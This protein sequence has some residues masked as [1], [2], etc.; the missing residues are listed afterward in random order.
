MAAKTRKKSSSHLSMYLGVGQEL[1][2]N[3]LPTLR[4]LLRYGIY[5]REVSHV[6][7]LFY[8]I[9]TLVEDMMLALMAQWTK[10]N[11]QL[12]HPIL[13]HPDTIRKR[14]KTSWENAFK[15]STGRGKLKEREKL[16]LQLD[17]LFDILYC[18][19]PIYLCS[20]F[21][22]DPDDCKK[23]CHIKCKCKMWEKIPVLELRFIRAERDKT[24][25]NST[26]MIAGADIPE[27]SKQDKAIKAKD[28]KKEDDEIKAKKDEEIARE[29][30]KREIEANTFINQEDSD[31]VL[32]DPNQN[33]VPPPTKAK[34]K[35]V[36]N[37]KDISN[38][39]LASM[40]HHTGL[41]ETAEIATAAW[42]DAGIITADD[43]HLVIDHNKVRRAQEKL[44]D[45]L[46]KEFEDKL[47][48]KG[49]GC[50]LFDGRI[51]ATKTMMEIEG[52]DKQ[53]PGMIKE[54]HYA[55][56]SEPGGE[57]LWHFVPEKAT[58]QK[59]HAEIIAD[60]I[61]DWLKERSID[62]YLV[63]I[64]GDST[65]VNTGWEGGAMQWVEK[66]LGRRLVWLVCDLHTGELGLRHLIIGIDGPTLSHNRWSGPLGGMLDTATELEVNPKFTKI[67]VGPPPLALD[68]QVISDLSTDQFYAYLMIKAI[69]SGVLPAR[70]ANLEIGPVSHARW[71]TTALRFCRIWISK[72]G[73]RGKLLQNLRL[74]IEFIVGVYIPNWFNVKV[75]HRWVEGPNHVLYQLELLRGQKKKVLEIVMPTIRRSAWYAHPEAVLQA[76]VCSDKDEERKEAVEKILEIRGDGNE[77]TQLGDI[78][79]RPRRTPVI[80]IKAVK[81]NEL[82]DLACDDVTEP[83]LTSK[84]TTAIVRKFIE[85][86]MEVPDW[87]SHTQS[88][89]RCVKMVTD[90]AAH[91]YS[92]DRRE[93]YIRSQV[94]SRQLMSRNNSK[95]DTS[96][97]VRF[98]TTGS[99]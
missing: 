85:Q 41:R 29:K 96:K 72:H 28:K 45:E 90:A 33:A 19:C 68:E 5:L 88:V 87:S 46:S 43:T 26:H 20:E 23:D 53:Y 61:V 49:T 92:H 15:L 34:Q 32:N 50:V 47:K 58:D 97:L 66:K 81:L 83:P 44:T 78:S 25:N 42:I 22:C 99:Q 30:K 62:N 48:V 56:C 89:E 82:V 7:K 1:P 64:G 69:R 67:V 10:A 98:R 37:T 79:V 14:L 13:V 65:N 8:P 75:K 91:V 94:I 2:L 17:K 35:K 40:R 11:A 71:L 4:D 36:R 73:L 3:Q 57:Y 80:N 76:M 9:D 6:D 18:H 24:G 12:K 38:V 21:E 55:V 60:H 31:D 27:S 95:Q 63:A 93:G 54:E 16:A 52:S 77:D 59:K 39:A 74:I 84:L 51:D 86:P 70:L